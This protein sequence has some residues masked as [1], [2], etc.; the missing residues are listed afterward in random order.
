[1]DKNIFLVSLLAFFRRAPLY[2][3]YFYFPLIFLDFGFNGWQIGILFS[4]FTVTALLFTLPTGITNDIFSI[5]KLII[6]GFVILFGFYFSLSLT[7]NFFIYLLLFFIGGLG[8][9]I[10]ETSLNSLILKIKTDKLGKKIGIFSSFAYFGIVIGTLL[11]G[12]LLTSYNTFTIFRTT[13]YFFLLLALISLLI[14]K[15]KTVKF[16]LLHYKKDLL[17]KTV[18]LFIFVLFLYSIHWGA[19]AVALSPFLEKNLGLNKIGI[20]IYMAISVTFLCFATYITGVKTDKKLDVKKA[21]Y[22]GLILSGTCHILMTY[23]NLF[24]SILFRII[25][26]VGDGI[27]QVLMFIGITRLFHIDRIGGSAS[28]VLTVMITGQFLG[29]LIF[30][31]IGYKLGYH[32]PLILSGI[33]TLTAF[34]L[35]LYQRKSMEH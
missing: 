9:N 10:T 15:T 34:L 26:E 3:T 19:E 25:H 32:I 17:R 4:L 12:F 33:L 8:V 5:K 27:V 30:G 20:G 31:Q 24:S 28:F 13:S 6:S 35:A 11:G 16:E 1:M 29:S 23:P 18:L 2:I 7:K 22:L 21:L 14:P